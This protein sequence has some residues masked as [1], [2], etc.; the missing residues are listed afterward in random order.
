MFSKIKY[1]FIIVLVIFI[2]SISYIIFNRNQTNT[3]ENENDTNIDTDYIG[4]NS[5][6][7]TDINNESNCK[8]WRL[9]KVIID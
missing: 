9:V 4:L 1:I 2:G 8:K 3:S 5:Y 6:E 7:D